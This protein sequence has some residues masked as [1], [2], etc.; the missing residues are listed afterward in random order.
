MKQ[1]SAA[2][3]AQFNSLRSDISSA[4]RAQIDMRRTMQNELQQVQGSIISMIEDYE[5]AQVIL[6][7]HLFLTN[8]FKAPRVNDYTTDTLSRLQQDRAKVERQKAEYHNDADT[9][10]EIIATVEN[11][12]ERMRNDAVE[13][14]SIISR[15]DVESVGLQ[16]SLE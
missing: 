1:V 8:Y 11:V 15:K 4:R 12:V 13:K 6:F 10:D 16:E 2:V 5:I 7:L 9:V 14:R 3:F